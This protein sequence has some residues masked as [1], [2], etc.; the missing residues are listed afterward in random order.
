MVSS[1]QKGFTLIEL[2]IV[3]AIIG[4]LAAIAVPNLL[5]ALARA[6]QKRSMAD[7]RSIAQAW[8]ARATDMG[9]Y[10]SAGYTV[11]AGNLLSQDGVEDLLA[12]TYMRLMPTKDGWGNPWVFSTNTSLNATRYQIVSAGRD[13]KA[14]D[15]PDGTFTQFD[16]DIVYTNG[17]FIS[18]PEGPQTSGQ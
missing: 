10:T 15:G 3:V 7:M 17:Q 2:L 6:R 13:G 9:S 16:C 4:V 12:P 8:E 11:S 1:R 14:V 18:Y 5:T